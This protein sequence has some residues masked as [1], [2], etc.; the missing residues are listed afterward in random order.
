MKIS[1]I[2]KI[3]I[4]KL[5]VKLLECTKPEHL[6]DTEVISNNISDI[7]AMKPFLSSEI[8]TSFMQAIDKYI[9][10][11]INDND[12]VLSSLHTPDI[13]FINDDG[14]F[15]IKGEKELNLF[16]ERLYQLSIN[17]EKDIQAWACSELSPYFG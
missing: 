2:E 15:E 13:G 17:V 3:I 5:Y 12:K 8:Y 11:I 9:G 1:L 7:K 6:S 14:H 16:F 4:I 10:P